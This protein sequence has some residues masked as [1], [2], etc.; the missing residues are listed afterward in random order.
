MR[1]KTLFALAAL[2]AAVALG[3]GAESAKGKSVILVQDISPSIAP[4]FPIIQKVISQVLIGKRLEVGDYFT[5]IAFSGKP[6]IADGAQIQYPRDVEA[7]TAIWSR[8]RP[9]GAG[10]DIGSALKTALQTSIELRNQGYANYDPLVIFVTDGEHEA[11]KGSPFEG[12]TVDEMFADS[13]IG[14]KGL[15]K[16]WYFV[17]IG[18]D[19]KDIKRIAELSGRSEE[20]LSIDDTSKLEEALDAWL[21]KI[22]PSNA[23]ENAKVDA[24]RF[25]VG[26]KEL[27]AKRRA[28]VLS[29]ASLPMSIKLVSSYKQTQ[30]AVELKSLSMTYQSA[31][32]TRVVDLAPAFEK[33]RIDVAPLKSVLST[34][35][36]HP[37]DAAA[38]RGPGTIKLEL[39]YSDDYIDRSVSAAYE[40]S[41]ATAGQ[42]FWLD[43]GWLIIAAAIAAVAIAVLLVL[44]GFLPVAVTMEMP[45]SASKF[46]AVKLS[47]GDRA[48]VGAKPGARFR[49]EGNFEPVVL[50][51]RRSGKASWEITARAPAQLKTTDGLK[52]YRLGTLLKIEDG[53]GNER[54][55]RFVARK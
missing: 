25:S 47:V 44:K 27:D 53:D 38:L 12:K 21:S 42:L 43:W 55:L 36:L 31:D 1:G 4:H 30:S 2:A 23:R 41:F 16:G 5:L 7:R 6:S 8:I 17:G 10:T 11:L 15:Y 19:L 28:N 45:G 32:K 9:E 52:P 48:E 13:L 54:S 49:L 46:K 33:G 22:P 24:L 51:L 37:S 20:F 26:N 14:D 50:Q 29:G 39:Q 3:A 18:K 34:A 40:V 35:S